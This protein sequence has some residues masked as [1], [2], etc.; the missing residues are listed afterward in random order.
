VADVELRQLRYF[1]AVA[2]E[3]SLPRAAARL[4]SSQQSLSAAVSQLERQ[5]GVPLL[6]RTTR[7]VA[8]TAAGGVVL[9]DGR[10]LLSAAEAMLRRVRSQAGGLTG[11]LRLGCSFDLQHVVTQ[12]LRAL[13]SREPDLDVN[14]TVGGQRALLED[15]RGRR[16]D[17]IVTWRRPVEQDDLRVHHLLSAPLVAVVR[18][19]DP[20]AAEA[21]PVTREQVAKRTLIMHA[22]HEAPGPYDEMIDHLYQ[23]AP[24]GPL[25]TIDVLTSGQEARLAAL[26]QPDGAGKAALLTD[27]AYQHLNAEGLAAREVDPPMTVT[28]DLLWL[29]TAPDS[30]STATSCLA[31]VAEMARTQP[32]G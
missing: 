12:L 29:P 23:G 16:L 2:E 10:R 5:V 13:R 3:L 25:S 4:H 14:V 27:F 9:E 26:Q 30:T 7:T 19:D 21:G 32:L 22:R 17:A 1:V 15:L 24:P 8:L 6:V 31:A 11:Q 18:D 20:L 28:V